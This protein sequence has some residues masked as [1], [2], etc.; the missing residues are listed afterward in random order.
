MKYFFNMCKVFLSYVWSISA[1]CVKNFSQYLWNICSIYFSYAFLQVSGPPGGNRPEK[2]SRADR[3]S[4]PLL[5]GDKARNL[6]VLADYFILKSKKK[7][8]V[9]LTSD[10]EKEDAD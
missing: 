9:R 8:D 2:Q 10:L 1:L 6:S 5:P 3:G 7:F 4:F